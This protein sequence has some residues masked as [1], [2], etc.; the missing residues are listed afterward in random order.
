M[1]HYQSKLETEDSRL[2]LYHQNNDLKLNLWDWVRDGDEEMLIP[3][4]ILRVG[5]DAGADDGGSSEADGDVGVAGDDLVV[6]LLLWAGGG[7]DGVAAGGEA[8][9]EALGEHVHVGEASCFDDSKV[10]ISVEVERL[11]W[12][13]ADLSYW[14]LL[15]H[16]SS[17]REEEKEEEKYNWVFFQ[18]WEFD[19]YEV[20]TILQWEWDFS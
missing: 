8:A 3:D 1:N 15:L 12:A 11:I 7:G 20:V 5:D 18:I 6:V 16:C 4:G 13:V 2:K 10:E 17:R 9:A 14:N 19:V